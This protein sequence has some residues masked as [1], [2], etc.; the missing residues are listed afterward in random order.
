[1][2][3]AKA[4]RLCKRTQALSNG[5]EAVNSCLAK[6]SGNTTKVEEARVDAF[7]AI[8]GYKITTLNGVAFF[9]R[10]LDEIPKNRG[11]TCFRE[12]F[13][14]VD[15]V[16]PPYYAMGFLS[17]YAAEI[18]RAANH[19]EKMGVGDRMLLEMYPPDGLAQLINGPLSARKTFD[20]FHSQ[21][22]ESAKAYCL[23]LC[24]VAI[25][26]LLPCIEGIVRRLGVA[27][28]INV[29]HDVGIAE[30]VQVF[31]RLQTKEI[32][33]MMRGYDWFPAK[34]I[35][36]SLLDTFH[37][38]VQMLG[39]ISTYLS[40]RLYLHTSS[41]PEHVTL[42]RHGI[43]HGFFHG[44]ATPL[45]Y[46]RLFNLLSALSFAAVMVEGSGSLMHPG[47]TPESEVLTTC[48]WKCSMLSAVIT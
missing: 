19:D 23:G 14:A 32:D 41:V 35:T 9:P 20:Q 25:V 16:L 27:S 26:G 44:Y 6:Q 3:F 46:L 8:D 1:M 45:N 2:D 33:M 30:L 7:Q 24:G 5:A 37:E 17:K 22:V 48:L 10:N 38:R 47:S 18:T 15:I 31:R 13:S 40:S 4:Y 36:V 43:S 29:Q 39:S 21:M 34:E 42:N 28:G 12:V 11:L